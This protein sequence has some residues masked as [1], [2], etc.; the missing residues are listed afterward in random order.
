MSGKRQQRK[1]ADA[2]RPPPNAVVIVGPSGEEREIDVDALVLDSGL[3][4]FEAAEGDGPLPP[5]TVDAYRRG[6]EAGLRV[7]YETLESGEAYEAGLAQALG[8][9]ADLLVDRLEPRQ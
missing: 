7:A 6:F 4:F 1:P 5:D 3:R 9:Y 8:F 2:Q